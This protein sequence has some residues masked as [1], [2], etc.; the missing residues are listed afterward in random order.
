MYFIGTR[1]P[2]ATSYILDPTFAGLTH[3]FTAPTKTCINCQDQE[4]QHTRITGTAPITSSLLDYVATGALPSMTVEDV[5][6]FLIKHLKWLIVEVCSHQVE[7]FNLL[8]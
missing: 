2:D 4:E 3:V 7:T 8:Y 6:P 1:D 5:L